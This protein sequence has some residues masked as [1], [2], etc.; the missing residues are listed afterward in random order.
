MVAVGK[1]VERQDDTP[2]SNSSLPTGIQPV[3]VDDNDIEVRRCQLE[4]S[5][6]IVVLIFSG[7][8]HRRRPVVVAPSR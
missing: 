7:P 5:D 4:R 8:W 3:V 6:G 2:P 1:I